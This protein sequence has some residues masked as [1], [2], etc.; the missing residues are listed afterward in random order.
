MVHR[1]NK[2]QIHKF[3]L[4]NYL[5]EGALIEDQ[6][7]NQTY[8]ASLPFNKLEKNLSEYD[9]LS[10]REQVI[11]LA[12]VFDGEGSFGVW[13]QGK[14]KK[15]SLQIKVETTDSDMVA[16]FHAMYG[17]LFFVL[18]KRKEHWKHTFRWKLSGEKAWQAISEMVPYMCKRRKEKFLE[19]TNKE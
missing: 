5:K 2:A 11:F 9:K 3:P 12:G 16:R 14:H 10:R 8:K 15:R 4:S 6:E 18:N 7:V 1:Q 19:I 17:G 13:S